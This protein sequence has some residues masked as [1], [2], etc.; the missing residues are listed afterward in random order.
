MEVRWRAF[1]E[2][3]LIS[4]GPDFLRTRATIQPTTALA[5]IGADEATVQTPRQYASENRPCIVSL[6][7]PDSS[8]LV[9][10]CQEDSA[11]AAVSQR[12]NRKVAEVF[13][14]ARD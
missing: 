13:F 12:G 14:D 6:P 9:T 5:W 11:R 2:R 7:P 4:G 3:G 1:E 10:P 8:N